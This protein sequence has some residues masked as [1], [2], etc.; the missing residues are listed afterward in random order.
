MNFSILTKSQKDFQIKYKTE[1]K[2]KNHYNNLFKN[3]WSKNTRKVKNSIFNRKLTP[4]QSAIKKKKQLVILES[5][6]FSQY[7]LIVKSL[8][9]LN[10]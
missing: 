4:N 7:K 3:K 9:K 6:I 10:F 1:I 5:K 8:W 2:N